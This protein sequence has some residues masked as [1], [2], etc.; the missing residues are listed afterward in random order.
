MS[1]LNIF[2]KAKNQE[3]VRT[4]NPE[5]MQ[6]EV[7]IART[8][9]YIMRLQGGFEV[10][11]PDMLVQTKGANVYKRMIRDDQ[12]KAAFF[13][14][15]AVIISRRMTFAVDRPEQAEAAEF[16][17]RNITDLMQGTWQKA[18]K[19]ILMGKAWGFSMTE[20]VFKADKVDGKDRWI[21][22]KLKSKPWYSFNFKTDEYGNIT[23]V[24]Q[25]QGS[26]SVKID[27]KKFIRY[28][29]M[30]EMDEIYGESD[31]KAAYRPYW[32]KDIISKYWNMYLERLAGGFIIA[33]PNERAGVV[34]PTTRGV[35]EKALSNTAG[36]SAIIMPVGYE[37]KIEVPRD[38]KAFDSKISKCDKQIARA[39]MM[40]NLLGFSEQEKVGSYAQSQTVLDMFMMGIEE[41]G[42]YLMDL[43]NEELFSQLCWW[44]FFLRDFPRA[45]FNPYTTEQ[46]REIAKAWMEA[47]AGK[48][49]T[50]TTED[51]IFTRELLDYPVLDA[52]EID[53]EKE[54]RRS[55]VPVAGDDSTK[56]NTKKDDLAKKDDQSKTQDKQQIEDSTIKQS[57][58]NGA[59]TDQHRPINI[60]IQIPPHN[61]ITTGDTTNNSDE[62][63]TNVEDFEKP[64]FEDRINFS[65]LKKEL[66][67]LE[68]DYAK[69]L[70]SGVEKIMN[71]V[72]IGIGKITEKIAEKSDL[73][74]E[75]IKKQ[76]NASVSTKTKSKLHSVS[77]DYLK[78][79]Y[80]KGRQVA[81][82]ALEK[83]LAK[84]PSDL[85]SKIKLKLSSITAKACLDKDWSIAHFIDGI[86]IE[87][88][89]A[90]FDSTAFTI[91]G[92]LTQAIID[93]AAQIMINGI[94]D[95]LSG[96][97]MQDQLA[98]ML[99]NLT[100]GTDRQEAARIETIVRTNLSTIFT[101]SQLAFYADPD[102]N[103]FVEALEYSSVLDERTT[104]C[105][106]HLNGAKYAIDD[107]IWRFITPPNHFNC[108]SI[109]IPVTI[110]DT[111]RK[112]TRKYA[113]NQLP[114]KGFG[115]SNFP[116]R[117]LS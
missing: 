13:S 54:R 82:K 117:Y 93:A 92:D 108:R 29:S 49:V 47:V 8:D 27:P 74:A 11:N 20:K 86:S 1:F 50:P 95:E 26:A 9:S 112:S 106:E 111:W 24:L 22:D 66:N 42:D 31:L 103:G 77:F 40:P 90:W 80:N 43:L 87:A 18:L 104:K 97:Q 68:S 23:N 70:G 37:G 58:S 116:E 16:L 100:G 21:L 28:V 41:E 52:D 109:L 69:D 32:E 60:N 99:P 3:E 44:N 45:K 102:L 105:C 53:Q 110:L 76:L 46:K 30:P 4:D 34:D 2:N 78:K 39:I 63:F 19:T 36:T 96:R 85:R 57:S 59:A 33:Q 55:M 113:E 101:Q 38:T 88:A 72:K 75:E 115:Q 15:L 56:D 67:N 81:L 65:T 12:V 64:M 94:R 51:E 5:K 10:Y 83:P 6:N 35:L 14:K 71:E 84:A 7:A 73:N 107:D 79:G 17:E 91:T 61:T 25:E 98:E 62:V 89:E 114:S 48:T